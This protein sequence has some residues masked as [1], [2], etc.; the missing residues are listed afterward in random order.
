VAG[1]SRQERKKKD[2]KGANLPNKNIKRPNEIEKTNHALSRVDGRKSPRPR[3]DQNNETDVRSRRIAKLVEINSVLKME[4][5]ELNK[6][7]PKPERNLNKTGVE[8]N[9]NET[10]IV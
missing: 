5:E 7:A 6:L 8:Q 4:I 1:P 2:S 10:F 3:L 9:L